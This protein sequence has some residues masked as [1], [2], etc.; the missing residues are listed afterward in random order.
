MIV[1]L[2]NTSTNEVAKKIVALRESGGAISLGRVLTLVVCAEHNEPTEGA[3]EAA[4]GA[5][6]EHPSRV[7]VV[8]RGDRDTES[9]LDAEIRV[10]GD[11]G[12][13]EVVV[14]TLEG[15]LANHPRSVVTPFLL[16]D[17]PVVT[18]WPGTAPEDP[19]ADPMGTLGRRRI[20][21]ASR[22]DHPESVLARRLAT[23]APGDSDLA[24]TQITHWRGLLASALGRPPHTPVT[25]AEVTGPSDSPGVDLLAGWLQSALHVPTRRRT[26]SFEVRLVRDDGPTVLAI[27][28]NRNAVL[29]QPGKPDGRVAMTRRDLPQL[30]VEEL[31]R[32]D[33]DEV[34]EEAL[35]GVAAVDFS[36][37]VA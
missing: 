29:S 8:S 17:T 5:S 15:D 21:D 19:M 30:L 14:L 24:W 10:G 33:V 25:S 12:A 32:L 18:W 11:A 36:E 1:E 13:S 26:G 37:V 27:D 6:R 28:E 7:I 3:I 4:I 31:R 20:L 35:R 9:R 2:P 34:Y 23:Y 16:P 22:S